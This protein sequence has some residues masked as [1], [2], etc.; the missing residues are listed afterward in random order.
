MSIFPDEQE[1]P[2]RFEFFLNLTDSAQTTGSS[3]GLRL[4]RR[5]SL[6][7]A[8]S[9][10]PTPPRIDPLLMTLRSS[11]MLMHLMRSACCLRT[12]NSSNSLDQILIVLSS[13]EVTSRSFPMAATSVVSASWAFQRLRPMQS[14]QPS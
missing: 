2:R 14:T 6:P 12:V 7:A 13:D 10:R 1:T 11:S 3:K 9:Q 8:R 4:V 5:T